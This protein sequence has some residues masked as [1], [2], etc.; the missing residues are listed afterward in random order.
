MICHRPLT[1]VLEDLRYALRVMD[2]ETHLGL[3][4][5]Y[6]D[7]LRGTLLHQIAKVEA[8]IAR[9]LATSHNPTSPAFELT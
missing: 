8:D 2:E 4:G 5:K 9:E 7:T 3:D 6:A 1:E